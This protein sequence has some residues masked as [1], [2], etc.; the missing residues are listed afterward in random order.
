[1]VALLSFP[2]DLFGVAVIF[3]AVV[4]SLLPPLA[5]RDRVLPTLAQLR[6]GRTSGI[7][8]PII[9]RG[10]YNSIKS[11]RCEGPDP[12]LAL[13][14]GRPGGILLFTAASFT[15]EAVRT[16]VAARDEFGVIP[17]LQ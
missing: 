15:L 9:E 14:A 2:V 16:V 11:E 7:G 4:D 8:L 12:A 6:Y 10:H 17:T 1:M 3:I 5:A 13:P